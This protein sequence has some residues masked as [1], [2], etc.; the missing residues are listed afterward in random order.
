VNTR[1]DAGQLRETR[2]FAATLLFCLSPVIVLV[3]SIE[4]V[5]WRV[6]ETMRIPAI[7]QWQSERSDRMW[8][9]GDGRSYLAYKVARVR[10]LK[11]EIIVLGQSRANSFRAEA[12]VPYSFFNA[13]LTAW[14]FDHYRRF[15][16][17][18]VTSDYAPRVLIF[19]FD[20]WMFSRG[21]DQHWTGRFYEDP[22][23]H[24]EGV[25]II[26]DQLRKDPSA[27]L[28]RL[29]LTD[30]LHGLYA[31]MSGDGFRADGSLFGQPANADPLR[32]ENDGTGVGV[33]PV[34]LG[35]GMSGEQIAKFEQFV[36]FAKS[37]GIALIG[38]QV[39]YY[40][41]ILNGLNKDPRAGLWQEFRSEQR[42][43]YFERSGVIF[44]DFAD[45]PAYRDQP[46]YFI[47]SIHPDSRVVGHIVP[48]VL[49]D[50]RVRA[51][52]PKARDGR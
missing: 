13:G 28:R 6:G 17:L 45:V 21:F 35:D 12:F 1:R 24:I 32:L 36:G 3:G 20:Y 30:G 14:T 26:A 8:R 42:R 10:V 37:R 48:I 19:N 38:I 51:V 5:A 47:D 52:L 43:R 39:P 16:E 29:S 34:E 11:P 18:V 41:R 7:A 40:A 50:P 31:V 4:Y 44:F 23:S 25:K 9:G 46:G 49:A 22:A 15:L 2:R 27:L 33:P